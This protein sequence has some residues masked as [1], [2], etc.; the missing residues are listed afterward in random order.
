MYFES[1]I[2]PVSTFIFNIAKVVR[3]SPSS[4][5]ELFL[6]GNGKGIVLMSQDVGTVSGEADESSVG[7]VEGLNGGH[8]LGREGKVKD[9]NVSGDACRSDRLRDDHYVSLN[10]KANQHL[11]RRFAVLVG[12]CLQTGVFQKARVAWLSPRTVR[13]AQWAVGC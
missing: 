3:Q 1:T 5:A 12:N 10:L 11:S 7:F 13:G 9:G 4:A 8:L 2:S 6:V